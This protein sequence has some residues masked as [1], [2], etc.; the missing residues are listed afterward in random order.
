MSAS[1]LAEIGLVLTL[2]LANGALALSELSI[3]SSRPSR[4]KTM[5]DRQVPGAEAALLLAAE[6]GRFLSAVQV[7][8]SLVG[9]LSG[10]ISG[11]VLG[12][13]LGAVLVVAGM[14]ARIAEPLAFG[15]VVAVI[16]YVSLII[17]E[18]VPKQIALRDPEAIASRVAPAMMVLARFAGPVVTLLDL[19]GRTVMRLL[20]FGQPA[21]NQV[22]E[23]EIRSLVAEAESAGVLEPEEHRMITGVLRLAD[24]SVAAVMT[25][26]HETEMIDVGKPDRAIRK[27]LRECVHSRVVAY[28]GNPEEILGVLQA[29]DVADALLRRER[30]SMHSLVKQAPVIPVTMDALDVVDV[31]K[32]STIHIALVHDEYGHFQGVVTSADI[33]ETIVGAFET[34]EGPAEPAVVRRA[35]GSYLISG[36]MPADEF[37]ELLGLELPEPRSFSTV[38]GLVLEHLGHIP[39]TG[40]VFEL[41]GWQLEVVD[42]DGRRVDKILAKRV[43]PMHRAVG[44]RH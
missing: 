11:A 30:F 23:E 16:T 35:D 24:R 44:G 8:I 21:G 13:R 39:G 40:E 25:P 43:R 6:P 2:I 33:L 22:T 37:S 36:T 3:V 41:Q 1:V 15:L 42:L 7:G 28:D 38:A 20:G 27:G 18:L 14:T 34:E 4:L 26:R 12:E 32:N 10:A 9:V 29:K 17:G 19:S 31:L 5:V